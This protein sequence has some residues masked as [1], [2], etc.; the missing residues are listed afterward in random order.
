MKCELRKLALQK[1]ITSESYSEFSE[2]LMNT[3]TTFPFQEIDKMTK[4]RDKQMDLVIKLHG[5]C[6]KYQRI[7]F[8]VLEV[9]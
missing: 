5:K 3:I 2:Q 6:T 9:I 8:R 7:T 1:N 4:S